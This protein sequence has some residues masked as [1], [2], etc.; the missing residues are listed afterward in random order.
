MIPCGRLRRARLELDSGRG[1]DDFDRADR[2]SEVQAA[3]HRA[4]IADHWPVPL[5]RNTYV[6]K[7]SADEEFG[8][9]RMAVGVPLHR[10]SAEATDE[11]H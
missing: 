7:G 6:V 9:A 2:V 8:Q 1:G 11:D 3:D 5:L 10:S 4:L